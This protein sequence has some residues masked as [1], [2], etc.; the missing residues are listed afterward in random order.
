MRQLPRRYT[1]WVMDHQ[2]FGWLVVTDHHGKPV[3]WSDYDAISRYAWTL[4]SPRGKWRAAQV[5]ET[6][7]R[8]MMTISPASFV[9]RG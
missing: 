5:I 8:L 7:G 1:L 2:T 9:H 3:V 4:V 6:G